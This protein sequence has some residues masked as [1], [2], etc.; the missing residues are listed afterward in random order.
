[1]S[2]ARENFIIPAVTSAFNDFKNGKLDFMDDGKKAEIVVW[3]E[4]IAERR[5]NRCIRL[6]FLFRKVVN[7]IRLCRARILGPRLHLEI[8]ANMK[9]ST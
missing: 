8:S 5:R 2:L 7:K 3:L 4:K 6:K 9:I 1:M